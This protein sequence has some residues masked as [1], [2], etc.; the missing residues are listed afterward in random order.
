MNTYSKFY[1]NVYLAKC[2]EKH[3]KGDIINVATK[4]GKENECIVFNI[5]YA[6]EGFFYY[7]IVRADGMNAQEY[8]KKKVEKLAGYAANAESKSNDYY[9]ASNKDRDFLSLCE[10]IK[11]GHHSEKRH[12]KTIQQVHDNMGKC[13]AFSDKAEDYKTR[14]QYWQ[15]RENIINLSMP[16]S[17]EFFEYKVEEAK[18]Y[19]EG[20]KSGQIQLPHSLAL[21]YAKKSVNDFVKKLEIAKKLWG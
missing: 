4:Y 16:E 18:M 8:A 5:V 1:P 21:G 3:E 9:K 13:V 2:S 11:V 17:F 12:R 7:S 14:A 15:N 19:H 6:K 20:L 10:P